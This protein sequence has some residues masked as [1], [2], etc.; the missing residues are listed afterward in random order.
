M[1]KKI[2][3]KI[4]LIESNNI[5]SRTTNNFYCNIGNIVYKKLKVE[6]VYCVINKNYIPVG[7]IVPFRYCHYQFNSRINIFID[8]GVG[9]NCFSNYGNSLLMCMIENHQVV[10]DIPTD[11]NIK[12]YLNQYPNNF[13]NIQIYNENNI[14]LNEKNV[15]DPS[16]E[17]C[18]K[19]TY[20][21]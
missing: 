8:F 4:L 11:N 14:V 2:E 13:I 17:L 16:L 19:F 9:N 12:Y 5:I 10:S 1:D 7:G 3:E 20:E 6:L 18:L 15:K 21:I